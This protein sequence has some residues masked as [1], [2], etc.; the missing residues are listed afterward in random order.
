[1]LRDAATSLQESGRQSG[2]MKIAGDVKRFLLSRTLPLFKQAEEEN[3]QLEWSFRSDTVRVRTA[4]VTPTRITSLA[5]MA[6][7]LRITASSSLCWGHA[8]MTRTIAK[9][10]SGQG[11]L[12]FGPNHL[13]MA[14]SD[15][16]KLWMDRLQQG[17]LPREL[18][19]TLCLLATA[20]KSLPHAMPKKKVAES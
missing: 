15:F 10:C 2:L 1:M 17:D 11:A 20:H 6:Y 9:L 4:G 7:K 14:V 3:I 5:T 8:S 19:F 16:T 18:I 12:R 13:Q